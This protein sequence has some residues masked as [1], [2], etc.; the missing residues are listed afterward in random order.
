MPE[1]AAA[2]EALLAEAVPADGP[3]CVLA[4]VA[5]GALQ[6]V[7]ARGLADLEHG[8]RLGPESVL[9]VAS[10]SKTV[11]GYAVSLLADRGELDLDAPVS[12]LLDRFPFDEITVRHLLHHVSGLRDQWELVVL[13][14]RSMEDVISTSEVRELVARQRE[15]NFPPGT[16]LSYSNTGYTL[17]GLVVERVTGLSLRDFAA[18]EVFAPLGMSSSRFVEDHHEVVPGRAGS[19]APLPAGGFARLAL[20]YSTAGA[21]S[22][23]TTAPDL[24]RWALHLMSPSVRALVEQRVTLRDGGAVSYAAGVM[25]AHRRGQAVVEHAGSDAGYRAHLVT[26]PDLGVAAVAVS[27]SA[28]C[29]TYALAHRAADLLLD[30][31]GVPADQPMPWDPPADQLEALAGLYV[32]TFSGGTLTVSG[33][34][35]VMVGMLPFTPDRPGVLSVKGAPGV[36]LQVLP[37]VRLRIPAMSERRL[38]RAER[39]SPSPADLARYAG[40]F[41]SDELEQRW[42]VVASEDGLALEH[43]RWG[44]VPL[45]PTVEHGFQATLPAG[46]GPATADLRFDASAEE[47]RVTS[48]RN[49]RLLFRR[50]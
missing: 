13:S 42:T 10:V 7:A 8:V 44:H 12:S 16:S 45:T 25:H 34:A 47:L 40:H 35:P 1:L 43:T 24:A 30:G 9:H 41:W 46:L 32:D 50:V 17:L 6:A 20:S 14:G 22:L 36:E 39:W 27:N 15:L 28:A 49:A 37:D 3:G 29:K 18:K 48:A 23:N 11:V 5:D 38:V 4:V 19:Y 26:F 33:T 21:T 2:L 31:L